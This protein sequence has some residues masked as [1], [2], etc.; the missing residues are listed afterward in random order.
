MAGNA[1]KTVKCDACGQNTMEIK[2]RGNSPLLYVHCTNKECRH[3]NQTSS[4]G[5]QKK[6]RGLLEDQAQALPE[7]EPEAWKPTRQT[8]TANSAELREKLQSEISEDE[9]AE[10]R[11]NNLKKIGTGALAVL[12]IGLTIFG[13]RVKA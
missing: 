3:V 4:P 7:P 13:I 1:I 6:W 5:Y 11:K 8:Q 12:A 10:I 2:Q 9:K